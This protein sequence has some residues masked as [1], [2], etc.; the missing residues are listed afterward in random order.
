MV[1]LDIFQPI[2]QESFEFLIFDF[3]P[4]FDGR[5]GTEIIF[6]RHIKLVTSNPILYVAGKQKDL[7]IPLHFYY[8]TPAKRRVNNVVVEKDI[9]TTHL[10][11][12]EKESLIKTLIPFEEVFH[13]P[14]RKLTCTTEIE[15][16]IRTSDDIPIYQ[17]SY[18]YPI[19]YKD[20]VEKQIQ[21]LLDDGIIRPSRSPWN[22]PVWIVP[23]KLD[24]LG[25]KKFRLVID[26]RNTLAN[27]VTFMLTTWLYSE[28][29]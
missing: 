25:Q 17:K 22:S 28:K 6:N 15:C 9:R 3:H 16:N 20:E 19:S 1:K 27:V 12:T 24:A 23:K 29:T 7:R 8:L 4:F 18:L 11:E 10:N 13:D 5:T 26:Y 14:Q 2:L 21:K